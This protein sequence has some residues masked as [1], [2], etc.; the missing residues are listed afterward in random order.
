MS[1]FSKMMAIIIK[2]LWIFMLTY[3]RKKQTPINIK[4]KKTKPFPIARQTENV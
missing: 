3:Y 4:K 2:T 1:P